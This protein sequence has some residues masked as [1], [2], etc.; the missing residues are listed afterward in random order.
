MSITT[1]YWSAAAPNYSRN[2]YG[3]I[4]HGI[5]LDYSPSW[6]SI[7]FW[8]QYLHSFAIVS[9]DSRF[10]YF[11][12]LVSSIILDRAH[13][14]FT[15]QRHRSC[16]GPRD[17]D[18]FSDI[19]PYFSGNQKYQGSY[20]QEWSS[21]L[22]ASIVSHAFIPYFD[23]VFRLSFPA[24]IVWMHKTSVNQGRLK[25][26]GNIFLF[27]SL[28]GGGL[29]SFHGAW[30]PQIHSAVNIGYRDDFWSHA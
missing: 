17:L 19:I 24:T 2:N 30:D 29:F 1:N 27:I 13:R 22:P 12:T 26:P 16:L 15:S 9:M 3:S 6:R 20:D 5:N 18:M 7:G 14:N 23:V 4:A 8:I 21:L 10:L 25:I 28:L 11:S